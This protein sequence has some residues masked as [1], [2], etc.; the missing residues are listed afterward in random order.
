MKSVINSIK[1]ALKY[2]SIV[3][4]IIEIFEFAV[5]RL[6]KFDTVTNTIQPEIQPKK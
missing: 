2:G 3:F 1:W 4:A 6:E 5:Q